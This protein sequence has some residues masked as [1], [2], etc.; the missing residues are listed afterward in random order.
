MD[1]HC[2]R[3]Y[4]CVRLCEPCMDLSAALHEQVSC[5]GL[6]NFGWITEF[7]LGT[8]QRVKES[9]IRRRDGCLTPFCTWGG[10]QRPV[11]QS[12]N[13]ISSSPTLALLS[14]PAP[15]PLHRSHP[16]SALCWAKGT[17]QVKPKSQQES[18]LCIHLTCPT[19]SAET[20]SVWAC[21]ECV[22]VCEYEC[23]CKGNKVF[24]PW[25]FLCEQRCLVQWE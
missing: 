13:P 24:S 20:T 25:K 18:L 3:T 8:L 23:I 15:F 19:A 9:K 12:S 10:S 6:S 17:G 11:F 4:V 1:L 21:G 5:R 16:S 7:A 22:F 2:W 14:S